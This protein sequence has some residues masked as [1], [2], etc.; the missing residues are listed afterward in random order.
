MNWIDIQSFFHKA[1]T[2]QFTYT[3]NN[4]VFHVYIMHFEENLY[5]EG[6]MKAILLSQ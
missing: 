5:L 1:C 2:S 3:I 4:G 6:H